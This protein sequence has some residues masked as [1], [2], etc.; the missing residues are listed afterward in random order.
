MHSIWIPTDNDLQQ[1]P[2]VFFTSPDIRDASVLDHSISPSLLEEI[3]QETDDSLLQH[4][5][6]D[7]FGELKHRVVQQLTV[8]WDSN[9]TESGEHTLHTHLHEITHAEQD[10][11]SLRPYLVGNL[12]RSSKILTK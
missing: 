1:Y 10:W 4:S 2:H 3:N 8:F 9:F 11:K 7:E 6:S 12:K 5:I